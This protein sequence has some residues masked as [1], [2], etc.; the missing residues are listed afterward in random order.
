MKIKIN[1]QYIVAIIMV[2]SFLYLVFAEIIVFSTNYGYS[3]IPNLNNGQMYL[4]TKFDQIKRGDIVII[5][6]MNDPPLMNEIKL[7]NKRVIGLPNDKITICYQN[8]SIFINDLE[9]KKEF[10]EEKSVDIIDYNKKYNFQMIVYKENDYLIYVPKY[11]NKYGCK[12]YLLDQNSYFVL[13]D[14]R[15]LSSDSQ[16]ELGVIHKDLITHKLL[17]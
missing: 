7:K 8:Y 12:N 15:F 4:F 14:N 3:M 5:N 17:F 13:G 9:V 10:V 16:S 11:N 1:S 2:I 6:K